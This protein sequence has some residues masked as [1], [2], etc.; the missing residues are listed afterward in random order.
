M[1]SVGA[2]VADT[3]GSALY[4][5]GVVPALGL[6]GTPL[7]VAAKGLDGAAVQVIA[8]DGIAVL[9]HACPPEP[10]EGDAPA[11][12]AWV[13]AQHEVIAEAFEKAGTI[14]PIRFDSIVAAT[15]KP[16][17]Q[18]LEA[19]LEHSHDALASRLDDLL[20]RVELG[21]QIISAAPPVQA[22]R[23][24]RAVPGQSRGREYFQ[25]QMA[26]R[27]ERERVRAH[28]DMLAARTF[29][30]LTSRAEDLCLNPK[31]G[32]REGAGTDANARVLLDAAVLVPRDRISVIGDYLGDVAADAAVKVRFTG[33]WPPYSF[34]GS[35]EMPMLMNAANSQ[36]IDQGAQTND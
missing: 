36:H 26:E 29:E 6:D 17:R 8:R 27:K 10:Y 13:L 9:T 35:L 11:V 14:L 30:E 16:A 22:G 23:A 34:V 25:T 1:D 4:L 3:Q 24:A 19:W 33:P 21:V 28:E 5:Y 7:T 20:G 32:N 18:L 12:H 31:R 15:D 2:V